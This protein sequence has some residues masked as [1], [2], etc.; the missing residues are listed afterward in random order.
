M[1][2]I[3]GTDSV[4]A[5]VIRSGDVAQVTHDGDVLIGISAD[6]HS[7]ESVTTA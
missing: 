5:S 1:T 6:G 4:T 2:S 7:S 3:S